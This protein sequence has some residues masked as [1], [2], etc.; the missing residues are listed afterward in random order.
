MAAK[1][2]FEVDTSGIDEVMTALPLH[3]G[4]FMDALAERVLTLM[5][6]SFN[7]SPDGRSYE[8]GSGRVHVASVQGYPPNIDTGT[9]TNSLRWERHGTDRR[10]IHGAEYGLYLEDSTELDRPFIGPAVVDANKDVP[11]LGKQFLS[12]L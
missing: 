6:L 4:K 8:R 12:P 3:K 1:F 11:A 7:T 2:E 9:L 5:K 10:E